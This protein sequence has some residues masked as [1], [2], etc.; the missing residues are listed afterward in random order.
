M[1]YTLTIREEELLV[2]RNAVFSIP[3]VEGAAFLLCGDSRT[4][5]EHRFL[6][7]DVLPVADEHYRERRPDFLSLDSDAYV[8]A[9]NKAKA[10]KL[11]VIFVHSHPGGF[12][13]YSEQDDREEPKLQNFVAARLPERVPGSLVLTENGIIGRVWQDGGFTSMDRVRV[14]GQR[15]QFHDSAAN[16]HH[17][18]NEPAIPAF[19]DRQVRAF[20]P[21]IQK[22][23]GRLHVGVV[24][25]GG[26]GSAV[27][28]EL[29][30]LGVTKLSVY[31]GDTFDPSNVN[32]VYGSGID[33]ADTPKTEI[34]LRNGARIGL[35]T[36]MIVYP[37]H[38]TEQE[39]AKTLCE[40]DLVFGCT[41]K[42][43][44]RAILVQLALRYLI[45]VFDMGVLVKSAEGVISDVV[46]R[47]TTLL[48]GEA[49]LFC[50][51]RISPET[52]R[53]ESLGDDERVALVAEG[54]APE[55]ATRSP[56]V[57]PFTS[58]T[59][60]F[61]VSE[62]LHRLT[63]YMGDARTSSEV[64]V[65]FDQSRLRTNRQAADPDCLCSQRRVWGR[66]DSRS[67]LDMTWAG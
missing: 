67:F 7:R 54:Y 21:D 45:P 40:C 31:D 25:A 34:A 63:G 4:D 3:G 30:R 1:R 27:I 52:I 2:L 59:A 24:G 42:E 62:L 5:G 13:D 37:K 22:L 33:D 11:S 49:C 61:A 16:H 36:E 43:A 10:A 65:F 32:R 15:F 19:F 20:G 48:P 47:V 51:G 66:G 44:P 9:V 50:R 39:V 28:E 41:D 46:V 55:L 35:G 14:I 38:I 26:T 29:I 64:L 56:A 17:A 58:A 6:V 57:I 18:A 23:L 12:L 8:G 53:L 60:S